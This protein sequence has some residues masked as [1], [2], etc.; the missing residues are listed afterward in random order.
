MSNSAVQDGPEFV[1]DCLVSFKRGVLIPDSHAF[2]F[3]AALKG[4]DV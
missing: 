1:G 2:G 3:V 4:S